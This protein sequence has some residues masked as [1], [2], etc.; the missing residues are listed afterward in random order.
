MCLKSEMYTNRVWQGDYACLHHC[1]E[2]LL[3]NRAL[4]NVLIVFECSHFY[5]IL[6]YFKIISYYFFSLQEQ[7]KCNSYIEK[8]M[9]FWITSSLSQYQLNSFKKN[10]QVPEHWRII[11]PQIR[12]KLNVF[13]LPNEREQTAQE[14]EH[15]DGFRT[16]FKTRKL[17][18][19]LLPGTVFPYWSEV[20]PDIFYQLQ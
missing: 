8:I 12:I 5:V 17:P 20:N 13:L 7:V 19:I 15:N 9:I 14:E 11:R 4:R 6:C 2:K 10:T 1:N 16:K 18:L 3:S